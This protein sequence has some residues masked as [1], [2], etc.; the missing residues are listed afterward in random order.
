MKKLQIVFWIITTA[1]VL[2]LTTLGALVPDSDSGTN[3][4]NNHYQCDENGSLIRC[5]GQVDCVNVQG[6]NFD[7]V[8][9]KCVY[10]GSQGPCSDGTPIGQCSKNSPGLR[11][12]EGPLGSP[13]LAKIINDPCCTGGTTPTTQPYGC[14][15][16]GWCN[17]AY[18]ETIQNCPGDCTCNNDGKCDPPTETPETCQDCKGITPSDND[19]AAYF[20]NKT[21]SVE[22][23][24]RIYF[25]IYQDRI[26]NGTKFT[27][28]ELSDILEYSKSNNDEKDLSGKL[29]TTGSKSNEIIG[30]ILTR[31][32]ANFGTVR[33]GSGGNCYMWTDVDGNSCC[34]DDTNWPGYCYAGKICDITTGYCESSNQT[35]TT[36]LG[37]GSGC[38]MTTDIDG[39]TCCHDSTNWPGFCWPNKICDPTTGYCT[40]G[41][42]TT[43]TSGGTTTTTQ[44]TTTCNQKCTILGYSYSYCA[45]GSCY[46]GDV[47][48]IGTCPTGYPTCCCNNGWTTTTAPSTTC[49]DHS[50]CSQTC[51][52]SCPKGVYGCC[53]GCQIG[54]CQGGQC[55]CYTSTSYCS[56]PAYQVGAKCQGGTTTTTP[57]G[58][59]YDSDGGKNYLTPGICSDGGTPVK[60]TCSGTDILVESYCNTANGNCNTYGVR[61]FSPI[62]QRLQVHYGPRNR[63]GLLQQRWNDNNNHTS[64]QMRLYLWKQRIQILQLR[65]LIMLSTLPHKHRIMLRPRKRHMLLHKL[66]KRILQRHR[67]RN[68]T[69][70]PTRLRN[71]DYNNTTRHHM[72]FYLW[73]QRIQ[74]LQ[75]RIL[76]MLSTLPHKYRIMLRTR[77]RN[78]LLHKLRKRI[79]QR[80][81]R[82]NST[83]LPTRLRK[84]HDNNDTKHHN[85]RPK[86]RHPGI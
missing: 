23:Y 5:S 11:C 10:K 64:H 32:G 47:Q 74:I 59:C 19:D 39:E 9:N 3:N 21:I 58:T 51:S 35:T 45:A 65:I 82:R 8:R 2:S 41:G 60:D 1:F 57:P 84:D 28:D 72:R 71:D 37:G 79:L 77:K 53:S 52:T 85:V 22:E 73:K 54:Q 80:H 55:V 13:S 81:R 78:M 44:S 34:H 20:K 63:G 42:T 46:S 48:S 38:Y 29:Y 43:T 76:I 49:T 70:L 61:L 67:R 18:G 17:P 36:T 50:Q 14:N 31:A 66:R 26:A 27:D 33:G 40:S 30:D 24:N 12:I 83:K 16:D 86:M 7:C 56:S 75:L 62:W 4:S 25:I 15:N 69:K 6:A 68:S